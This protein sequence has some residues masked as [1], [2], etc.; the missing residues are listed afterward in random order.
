MKL[1]L[2]STNKL[3]IIAICLFLMRTM[4]NGKT[5]DDGTSKKDLQT[6]GILQLFNNIVET[7]K[8]V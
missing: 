5:H 3:I 8:N 4:I 1:V 7:K 6:L 2:V